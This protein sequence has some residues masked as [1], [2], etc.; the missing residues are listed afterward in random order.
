VFILTAKG[1]EFAKKRLM[2]V[3]VGFLEMFMLLAL[4][5]CSGIWFSDEMFEVIIDS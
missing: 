5:D 4:F 1:A 3:L 2:L